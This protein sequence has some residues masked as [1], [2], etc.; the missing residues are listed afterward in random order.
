M[1]GIGKLAT[2]KTTGGT[3]APG[4]LESKAPA[5]DQWQETPG[6]HTKIPEGTR[7]KQLTEPNGN[8]FAQ[9]ELL[10]GL[11]KGKKIYT[12]MT[13]VL[14]D[15]EPTPVPGGILTYSLIGF[16][17]TLLPLEV[18]IKVRKVE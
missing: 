3:G 9:F 10:D 11:Y 4:Y 18:T 15:T 14:F 5:G 12:K 17:V 13:W 1:A 7:V 16:S 8:N 2:V 6:T